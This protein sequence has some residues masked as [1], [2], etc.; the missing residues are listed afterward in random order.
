MKA[1]ELIST[2]SDL[3]PDNETDIVILLIDSVETDFLDILQV[4]RN[5][6]CSGINAIGI[7]TR[8]SNKFGRITRLNWHER[9][10]LT[11]AMMCRGIGEDMAEQII[12]DFEKRLS[13]F[14][15]KG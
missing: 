9:L 1:K 15:M 12:S 6:D 2:I 13:G 11:K 7:N 14:D 10:E 4:V 8:R 5:A 3:Y